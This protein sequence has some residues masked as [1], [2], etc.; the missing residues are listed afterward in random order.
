MFQTDNHEDTPSSLRLLAPLKGGTHPWLS[1]R[2]WLRWSKA[3]EVVYW[4]ILG[5]EAGNEPVF[6][7]S[8][9]AAGG[10]E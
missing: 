2:I 7:R 1:N 3:M 5:T 6:G 8:D 9:P 10:L 4:G